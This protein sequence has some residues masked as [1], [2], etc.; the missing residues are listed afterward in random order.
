[1]GG[2]AGACGKPPKGLKWNREALS[3][4][5]HTWLSAE[6]QGGAQVGMNRAREELGSGA[7]GSRE[8]WA[9]NEHLEGV[10]GSLLHP[11]ET[12]TPGGQGRQRSI[13]CPRTGLPPVC[14]GRKKK[15]DQLEDRWGTRACW[16][17]LCLAVHHIRG[18]G[19]RLGSGQDRP[20]H[21]SG[22]AVLPPCPLPVPGP[23]EAPGL[24]SRLWSLDRPHIITRGLG[25]MA[26]SPSLVPP[27]LRPHKDQET[28][29]ERQS[30]Q[31]NFTSFVPLIPGKIGRQAG[32]SRI[33]Q[34]S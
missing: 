2:G 29:E 34:W 3:Q 8:V 13:L 19:S 25:P 21:S 16:H 26:T 10:R 18:R 7:P 24:E 20:G 23:L 5:E 28:Q 27:Q 32:I 6:L 30:S 9:E 1:M 4:A 33:R 22:R 12:F 31:N 17:S 11:L 15:N 14:G